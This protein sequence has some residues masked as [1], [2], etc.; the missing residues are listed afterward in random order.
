VFEPALPAF[1]KFAIVF[2]S[3]LSLNWASTLALRKIPLARG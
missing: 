2:I 1:V 3:T